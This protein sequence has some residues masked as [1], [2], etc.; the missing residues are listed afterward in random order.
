MPFK[1][2]TLLP[3]F[4]GLICRLESLLP[5][6]TS[7]HLCPAIRRALYKS[8]FKEPTPIQQSVWKLALPDETSVA[9]KDIIGIAETVSLHCVVA[10]VGLKSH[11]GLGQDAGLWYTHRSAPAQSTSG[12]FRPS[13]ATF[14]FDSSTNS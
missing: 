14:C 12:R 1:V 5:A 11:Q 2:G 3:S 8:G 13:Q 7:L 9:G 6:F 10:F 4:E